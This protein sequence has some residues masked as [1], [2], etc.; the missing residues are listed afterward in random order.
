MMPN[1]EIDERRRRKAFA[2]RMRVRDEKVVV[3]GTE[4]GPRVVV[5]MGLDRVLI[6]TPAEA[7]EWAAALLECAA[8]ADQSK[9]T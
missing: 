4:D 1:D 7:R 9:A 6:V 3:I 8:V 5:D 2:D